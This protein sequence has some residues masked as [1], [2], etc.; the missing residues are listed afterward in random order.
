MSNIYTHQDANIWKTWILMIFFF[1]L[2]IA[3]GWS[4]SYY[5]GN[6]DILYFAV[7]F[8][9]FMN[10]FS[11]WFSDKIVLKLHKARA[12]TRQEYFDLWNVTENLSITAGL[13][14]PKLYIVEDRAPN[15]F[16]T[17]RDK[18][19][20]VVC[21]TTGLLEILDKSELEGVIAHELSHIGNKDMLLS[22]IVVVM[23]GFIALLSDFFLRS[24]M[25]GNTRNRNSSKGGAV[26]LFLGI[27]MA[28]L[29]PVAATLIR[30][31][32]SRKRE[33]LAD[34]SGALLTRYP[35]GLAKALA[36]INSVSIPMSRANNATAHLFISNPFGSEKTSRLHRLFMTHPPVE[37]RIEALTGMTIH[38]G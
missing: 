38:H 32:I 6:S 17:G 24:Q 20:A 15:A 31:A 33:F 27:I 37:E 14:I 5:Y 13:P 22:T 21:V 34:A 28:I 25:W 11:Y 10:I 26:L 4:F 19:H 9:V 29:T 35:E 8:A 30:L 3:I 12:V 36:K 16:A 2:I 1:A 18:K 7:F 23:V